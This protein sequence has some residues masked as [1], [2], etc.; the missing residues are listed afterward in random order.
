MP[1]P[2]R[3]KLKLIALHIAKA[4]GLFAVMRRLT[5]RGVRILC[6]HGIWL[7][8]D[9]YPGDMM[10]MHRDTFKRRLDMIRT[11]G[12][13]VVPLS[14][15]VASLQD[16][17]RRLDAAVVITIDDGWF[18][19]Y[20]EMLPALQTRNMPATLYCDTAH[21]MA[22][23][24]V[25]HV[26]ATYIGLQTRHKDRLAAAEPDYAVATNTALPVAVRMSAVHRMAR[27]LDVD[28]E[29]YLRERAFEYMRPGELAAGANGGLDVQ[30]HTHNHN[31][32]G[33]VGEKVAE[34]IAA[35][36]TALAEVLGR[37]GVTFRHFCYP[38]GV[39]SPAIADFV[40]DLGL[41]SSTTL[42]KGIAWPGTHRQLLPRLL[43]GEEVTDI[44]FE[45]RL[46]GMSELRTMF[47]RRRV[48]IDGS[49]ARSPFQPVL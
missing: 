6:Y 37:D 34:E 27:V 42:A 24:P 9:S 23:Q 13:P 39:T 19:T 14:E 20:S 44:E 48:Q 40:D 16:G 15:A 17:A 28:I 25:A 46:C 30:L 21:L 36:R 29:P 1:L 8:P 33:L 43:D 2:L 35:N 22:G 12:Y 3:R 11:L 18:G 10:F 26:M 45:G 32:H 4:L 38:S 7:G 41:A 5:S 31:M 47:S 49:Y